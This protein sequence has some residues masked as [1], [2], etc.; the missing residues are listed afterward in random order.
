MRF[1]ECAFFVV[2]QARTD[3]GVDM[4]SSG[5]VECVCRGVVDG[6]ELQAGGESS[7]AWQVT[8]RNKRLSWRE[9]GEAIGTS[10]GPHASAIARRRNDGAPLPIS[11]G[12]AGTGT[13]VRMS[14]YTRPGV[15]SVEF[16]DDDGNVIDYGNRWASRGGT[17]PEDSYS[18]DEH[19]ERFAPLHT[20]AAALIDYLVSNCEVDVEEGHHVTADLLHA[21]TAEETV[22]AVRL[23]PRSD[24]C[25]PLIIVLTSYPAV[26][27]YAGTLFEE[28]YPS[29]GCNACDERWDDVAEELEWHVFAIVGGGFGEEVSEPRRAKW[30][31][32]RGRGLVKGMGQTVS[33]RLRSLKGENQRSGQSRAEDVPAELL[34]SARVTLDAVAA[35]SADGNWLP[36][37][38]KASPLL[39]DAQA[40]V[41]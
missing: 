35:V 15:E 2:G 7:H 41:A 32:D 12:K 25:A 9:V 6:T 36:W 10:G 31:Y 17:P 24:A 20:V 8:L 38:P 18:V 14:E 29:C 1:E 26:Q 33:Y 21:S 13:G 5:P 30:S 16:R 28:F 27:V 37:P 22:R 39:D 23:T 19:P 3:D 11:R 34:K 4:M 40:D